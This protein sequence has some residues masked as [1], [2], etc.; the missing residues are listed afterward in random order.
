MSEKDNTE[1]KE[2]MTFEEFQKKSLED[3]KELV[4]YVQDK[5]D[6]KNRI[7]YHYIIAHLNVIKV[8]IDDLAKQKNAIKSEADELLDAITKMS[9]ALAVAIR[10]GKM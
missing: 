9:K 8:I 3:T 7:R 6:N 4:K 10:D 2:Q 1:E 5:M